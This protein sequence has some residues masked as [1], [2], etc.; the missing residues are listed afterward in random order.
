[1][2]SRSGRRRAVSIVL[3][4]GLCAFA[5]T[6]CRSATKS[7]T[8]ATPSSERPVVVTSFDFT[9]SRILASIYAQA[10]ER[11]GIP[12]RR[13][14]DLGPRE[15]VAPALQQGLVDVVPEYV[16]TAL[17]SVAPGARV[18]VSDLRAVRAALAD[19]MAPAGL[20]ALDAAPA[21]NQNGLVV[22]RATADRLHLT[23]I[24]DLAA[25]ATGLTLAGP[26]EC[27]ERPYCL[28]GLSSRYGLRFA[29]FA[30]FA[31]EDERFTALE[32]GLADVAV[33][34]TTDADLAT[35]DLVVLQDD[36]RL[37]PAENVVPIVS[38]AVLSRYGNRLVATLD[39][40]SAQLTSGDLTF[41]NW[42]VAV[43]HKDIDAEAR[44]W[45]DRHALVTGAG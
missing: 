36:R 20:R 6:S 37:Q 44:G 1:V 40:V 45:L 22:T 17:A 21:Q 41:L 2:V 3:T 27:P 26:P 8:P 4:A 29:T 7:T 11:A 31:T 35:P 23:T 30:P 24:S 34:F 19:A 28:Q 39:A 38:D 33:L 14:D 5:F 15:L 25:V 13:E 12:V 10:L 42:R 9:E 16:G 18:D 32:E 43:G